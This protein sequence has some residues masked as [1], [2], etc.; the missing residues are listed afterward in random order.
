[1]MGVP[2]LVQKMASWRWTERPPVGQDSSP[3]KILRPP[4]PVNLEEIGGALP[5]DGSPGYFGMLK[6]AR[7]FRLYRHSV[8]SSS[9][10]D[11]RVPP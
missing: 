9:V 8:S 1:M 6:S 2:L 11:G 7:L 10:P 5:L 3:G 4:P